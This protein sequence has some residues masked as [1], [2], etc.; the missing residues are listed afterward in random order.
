MGNTC[1]SLFLFNLLAIAGCGYVTQENEWSD[2]G[3]SPLEYCNIAYKLIE[4]VDKTEGKLGLGEIV[5]LL[6]DPSLISFRSYI[7][8]ESNNIMYNEPR[9][10]AY[11]AQQ[12]VY[13]NLSVSG[14]I[15]SIQYKESERLKTGYGSSH[16]PYEIQEDTE[17][18]VIMGISLNNKEL[19]Q[20]IQSARIYAATLNSEADWLE[21]SFP[22]HA[23]IQ[24][25]RNIACSSEIAVIDAIG[26]GVATIVYKVNGQHDL[27]IDTYWYL[28]EGVWVLVDKVKFNE[29]VCGN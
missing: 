9:I 29:L 15:M 14:F 13:I 8:D 3:R 24:S 16:W 21:S 22:N 4:D 25:L 1:R 28:N 19:N 2:L 12:Q 17:V 23:F 18:P 5:R 27:F 11:Y 20:L 6:G 26:K 10:S 7:F